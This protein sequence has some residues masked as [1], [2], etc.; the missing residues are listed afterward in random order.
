MK[1]STETLAAIQELLVADYARQLEDEDSVRASE[2][3]QS[4]RSSL[5]GIGQASMGQLLSLLDEQAY[6][7]QEIC[8]CQSKGRRISRR[9]AQVLSVFGWVTYRRSHYQCQKCARRWTPL[10]QA[11][12]LRPGRATAPMAKLLGLA[13]ISVAFE[14]AR[15]HIQAYLQV[16][17]GVNTIREETQLIGQRQAQREQA[18]MDQ[19]QDLQHLQDR[20]RQPERPQRVYGSIDGA[21]VPIEKEW[22]EAKLVSWYQVGQRYGRPEP[23]AI[24]Q[25]YHISLEEAARFGQLLWGT[26]VA[27]QADRAEELVFVC[28][29]AAWIW[30]LVEH[31][32]PDAVQIVD[33][34]HACQYFYPLA[35]A[36]FSSEQQQEAWLAE[37]KDLL[38]QGQ[39]ATILQR[40]RRLPKKVRRPAN[41]LISYYTNNQERMRY[42]EFRQQQYLIGSGTVESSCKQI[43]TMRLK[44][45]GARWSKS[46]ASATAKARCAWLSNDW[47]AVTTLPIAA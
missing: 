30:K 20:E 41:Q 8:S 15:R 43:V 35:E 28:D 6:G 22:K 3:E 18:W 14:E 9:K 23:H 37:M 4:L 21:F 36:L 45:A 31:Y 11:H 33:W 40:C 16:E 39:A 10:D 5:Q 24:E 27:Y 26:A 7:C 38:W 2:L 47:E 12:Q 32:F 44:R 46:G 25:V 42:A 34:Y 13:G 19:S 17:V 1:C 29:G